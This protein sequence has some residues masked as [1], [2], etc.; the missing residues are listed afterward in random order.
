M[1]ESSGF[2]KLLGY[3]NALKLNNIS[4]NK[5]YIKIANWKKDLAY[6]MRKN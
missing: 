4:I 2:S 6:N 1:G 5:S 3:K